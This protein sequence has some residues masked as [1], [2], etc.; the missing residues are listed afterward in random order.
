MIT[1]ESAIHFAEN[2]CRL[3]KHP[4]NGQLIKLMPWQRDFFTRLYTQDRLNHRQYTKASLFIPKKNSKSTTCAVIGLLHTLEY[5]GSDCFIV[6]STIKQAENVF[7]EAA[8]FCENH[9]ALS[10]FK[11]RRHTRTIEDK[12]GKS[13][14]RIL[15]NDPKGLD[16]FN[17]NL[18]I[19][20]EFCAWSSATARESWDKLANAT[21]A[22]QN[23]L[24]IILSTAQFDLCHPG[25]EA[26]D[27]ALRVQSNPELDP[28]HLAI[29]YQGDKEKHAD[30]KE[31]ERCNPGWGYVL[32]PE[33]FAEDYAVA[34]DN[35]RELARFLTLRMNCFVGHADS[36]LPYGQWIKCA[37]PINEADLAG[38]TVL[39]GMDASRRH[40]L[41]SYC[42]LAERGDK[43]Y[44]LPRFFVPSHGI[45]RKEHEDGVPYRQWAS[46]PNNKLYLSPGDCID[47]AFVLSKL[48]EDCA[49]FKVREIGYDPALMEGCRQSYEEKGLRMVSVPQTFSLMGRGCS[50]L[51]KRITNKT[52]AHPDNPVLNWCVQNAVVREG[53][54]GGIMLDKRK[55]RKRIDGL[56]AL[57]IALSR[58]LDRNAGIMRFKVNSI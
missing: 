48:Q 46:N 1:A 51:E 10:R 16:G 36:W 54:T 38:V 27:H 17:A 42:I 12:K 24:K 41:T 31:W 33:S 55:S 2:Y 18:L 53:M 9:P 23:S 3:S 58:W 13:I 45:E 47:F 34:K 25:K 29:V 56:S 20:D 19:L 6:S 4:W 22:R 32:T 50:E 28:Q 35:P 21:I 57:I 26:F 14:L 37:E 49:R 30:P 11:V 5:P 44:A 8:H 7:L 40:D 43:L 39:C 15:A 52:I